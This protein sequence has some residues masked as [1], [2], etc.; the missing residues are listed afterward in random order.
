M[1]ARYPRIQFSEREEI[2][3]ATLERNLPYKIVIRQ[4]QFF[5]FPFQTEYHVWTFSFFAA[6]AKL[7]NIVS[8]ISYPLKFDK[9][10]MLLL[11]M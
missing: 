6:E 8:P 7:C 9:G 2:Y 1:V 11:L 10:L 3:L 4:E 5:I